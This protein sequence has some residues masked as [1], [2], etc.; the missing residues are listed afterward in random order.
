M[1]ILMIIMSV[2]SLIGCANLHVEQSVKESS[3]DFK[4]ENVGDGIY[5]HHGEH[6]DI[7]TGYQGDICNISFIVGSRGVAVIDTGGS[8]KVGRQLREAIRQ[9][10]SLPVLYVVNSHVHPDHIYGN[11]AFLADK[12]EF[13]GHEKLANAMESRKEQYA[14]LNARFLHEDAVGTEL[15]KPT[16]A[17]KD[18]LELDLGGRKLMLTAHPVAHTN[19]D[20]SMIDSKTGTL[21][22]GDLLFI[23]RTPVIES[24]VKGL[25]AEI[26]KLKSSPAKQVVPGHGPVT[27]DWIAALSDAQRYLNVLLA[28][29]RNSIKNNEGMEKSMDT[30]AASEKGKWKLFDVA[31]R[32]NVNTIYPALEWE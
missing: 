11:A 26:E 4:I 32:R 7:D 23:E 9:I 8:L 2:L 27:K 29:V 21:F 13:V 16:L 22:T 24:D 18:K 30:A 6:L 1:R 17:V 14:K 28:D 19:T 20:V 15:I 25:I 31:N 3:E 10:T 5:V 12:P